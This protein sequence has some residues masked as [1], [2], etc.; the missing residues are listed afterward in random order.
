MLK[1]ILTTSLCLVII[2]I[3]NITAQHDYADA[4][5]LTTYFYGANRC[6]DTKSWCHGACHTRDGENDGIDLSGGWHDCGDHVKF[7]QTNASTAIN[8][9]IGY[10]RFP[11]AYKDNYS[12]DYS[13]E[14]GNGIPDILDEVKIFTDYLF[15]ALQGG[16]VYY[17]VGDKRDHNSNSEPVYAS[18]LGV[19]SGGEPR[20]AYHKTEGATNFCGSAAASLALMSICY[21]P[22]KASYADSCKDKAI[23]YYEMGKKKHESIPDYDKEFYKNPGQWED[24]MALGALELYRA[25]GD[26]DY[27]KYAE[28]A[29]DGYYL[30]PTNWVLAWDNV[31]PLLGYELYMETKDDMYK[32]ALKI[33][34]DANKE[35]MEWCGYPH[36]AEWG[37]LQYATGAAQVALLYASISNDKD[38]YAL[39]KK[40]IDFCL[41]THDDLLDGDAPKDFSFVIGYDKLK[42]GDPQHPHHKAAFGKGNNAGTIWA[43]ETKN[44][45]SVTYEHKLLGALVGGPKTACAGYEDNI[46][47]FY[48]NE[49]CIYYNCHIVPALGCIIYQE[50]GLVHVNPNNN[51]I[52]LQKRSRTPKLQIS[53]KVYHIN[54]I[55][56]P[57]AELVVY[58]LAG[59]ELGSVTVG[60]HKKIELQNTLSISDEIVVVKV[61]NV[62]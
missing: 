39:G 45:G 34:L 13:E 8:L 11:L 43:N 37:S 33:E 1:N 20:E 48:T 35:K 40:I 12:Q 22:F 51:I 55:L 56:S 52:M 49:V 6:G 26:D 10:N 41:G 60:N 4:L 53:S 14:P 5:H 57:D 46:N 9:L 32:K 18:D 29:F 54:P 38:A 27:L 24:D 31:S 44:P 62:K 30:L 2:T 59:R 25:T 58:S 47:N 15:K 28:F 61:R 19:S 17:Q 7:G 16:K 3:S 23:E 36:F 42:G 50:E 21:R